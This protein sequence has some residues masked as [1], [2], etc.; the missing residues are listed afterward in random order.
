MKF[1]VNPEVQV[2]NTAPLCQIGTLTPT[3]DWLTLVQE[4]TEVP[5]VG[6]NLLLFVDLATGEIESQAVKS[7]ALE[8]SFSSKLMIRSDGRRIEV[9]GNPSR[10]GVAHSLD[11]FT[12]LSKCIALYN[13]LCSS[14]G[15]PEFFEVDDRR[16]LQTE[17]FEVATLARVGCR[18]TRLDLAT[19]YQTGGPVEAA[20]VVRA[21]GQITNAGKTPMVYGKGE[22][23]A[24]GAGSRH[25]YVK[26][27]A[28]GPEMEKHA[29]ECYEASQ[30][31]KA[32]GLLRH[33]VTLK[34]MW[35][36]KNG[37]D[38][39]SAWTS[40][41]TRLVTEKY[42]MHAKVGVARSSFSQI[43]EELLALEVPAGRARR[44]QEAA[45]AYLAGHVFRKAENIPVRSFYRLRADLR[46]VGLD[47]GAPLNVAA[48][49]HSV[50]VV[51]LSPVTVPASFRRAG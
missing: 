31:A 4:H 19:L 24:W 44:A 10:W 21:L 12:D 1:E 35:L 9:S 25:V 48:L 5:R 41:V 26:Y 49:R 8:G 47:I 51:D 40:E 22:T 7:M 43:Y 45:Y 28:K 30:W 50:R 18:I 13:S 29:P 17:E 2:S 46:M 20:I 23:V 36:A 11:G 42:A 6:K 27:Y 34:S 33:E 38:A 32:V 37:L 39:P 15:L 3:I 16:H 14:V